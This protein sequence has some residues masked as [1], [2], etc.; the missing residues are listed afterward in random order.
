LQ[1]VEGKLAGYSWNLVE[2]YESRFR[3]IATEVCPERRV[4]RTYACQKAFAPEGGATHAHAGPLLAEDPFKVEAVFLDHKIPCL[5]FCLAERFHVNVMADRLADMGL[6]TGPWLADM[7]QALWA[8]K[9]GSTRL[10]APTTEGGERVLTLKEA[11]ERLVRFSPGQKIAYVTDCVYSPENE[12]RILSLAG[13][14]DHLFIEAAFLD[15]DK[16]EAAR[17]HHLTARQAGDLARRAG[18]RDYTLL[19]FSPRYADR[20][21]DLQNEAKRAFEAKG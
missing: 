8:G 3:I 11:S 14:C 12:A 1:N 21:D 4:T 2:N 7:K 16:E 20:E 15:E 9:P 6:V 19:H 17:K 5:A 18:A 10:V 13:G